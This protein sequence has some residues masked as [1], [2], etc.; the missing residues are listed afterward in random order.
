MKRT[1]QCI[2]LRDKYII[3]LQQNSTGHHTL[4]TA[5]QYDTER[6]DQ[7]ICRTYATPEHGVTPA[8]TDVN[9]EPKQ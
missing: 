4:H 3:F 7:N 8:Q 1:T 5:M 2:L 9:N 6:T